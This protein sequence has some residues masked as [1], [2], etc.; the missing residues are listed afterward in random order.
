MFLLVITTLGMTTHS[1]HAD[2]TKTGSWGV[3]L[4]NNWYSQGWSSASEK[5]SNGTRSWSGTNTSFTGQGGWFSTTWDAAGG[6]WI[7][8][9]S[10][11]GS[12]FGALSKMVQNYN[13]QWTGTGSITPNNSTYTFGLKFNL[14]DENTWKDYDMT[15]SY[16][17]Y[18]ITH[19][20]KTIAQRDGTFI[21]TV[22]PTGDPVGYDC[23][24]YTAYWGP[25]KQ[26]WA[27]RRENT[28][29][30]PVNVQ[31]I[32]KYWSD[33]SG[34]SFDVDTWYVASG[35][36]IMTETFDT[37]GT[38]QVDNVQIPDLNTLLSIGGLTNGGIYE[39]EPK[40]APGKRLDVYGAGTANGSKVVI[41]TDTNGNNQRW[42]LEEQSTGIYELTPQHATGKRMDVSGVSTA[43]GAKA[44]LWD[45]VN[46]NNQRWKLELQSD[47]C[48]ELI[49]QHATGKRLD[50]SGYSSSNGADVH[51]WDDTN[52]DNQRWKL[53]KQ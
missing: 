4:G 29:S 24:E 48:Y 23:Y 35:F 27:W 15:T 9:I 51:S 14:A 32:L 46:G 34:T 39:L 33:N 52:A 50:V 45:D 22:Y 37:A 3:D 13:V 49:P 18:I 42:K 43:N 10:R 8:D 6:N 53:L 40:N 26:L 44:H 16:E 19:S 30:G 11:G 5:G 38:F 17:A 36:S 28:W 20:N 2:G 21:G 12:G 41:W 47:G 31:T 7:P 25:F 1:A